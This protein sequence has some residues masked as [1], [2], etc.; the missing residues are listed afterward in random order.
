MDN[1]FKSCPAMMMDQGRNLG[2]F[3]TDTRRN[4]YIKK[5]NGL[6]H[7][8]HNEYRLFLQQ[9]ATQIMNKTFDDLLRTQ[10]CHVNSCVHVYPTRQSP[11]T[12]AQERMAYD[13]KTD[14]ATHKQLAPLRKCIKQKPY[15]INPD[16]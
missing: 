12:F 5:I 7:R 3:R 13:S 11:S 10:S 14:M 6:E 4:E 1:Y 8:H 15:R 9:N 16:N 2:D